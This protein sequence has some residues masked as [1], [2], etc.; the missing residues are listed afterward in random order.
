MPRIEVKEGHQEVKSNCR[1]NR[2]N[3]IGKRIVAHHD[4]SILERSNDDEDDRESVVSHDYRV[5]NHTCEV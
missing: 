4:L 3:Q 5:N 1:G 2:N